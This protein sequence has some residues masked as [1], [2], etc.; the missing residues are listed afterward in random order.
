MIE[1]TAVVEGPSRIH[2]DAYVGHF[3]LLG[4]PRP[5]VMNGSGMSSARRWESSLG[6]T[7]EAGAVVEAY[8]QVADASTIA[9]GAS[10]GP[11][12]YVGHDTYIG[13]GAELYYS[14]QVFNR[15]TVGERA[16]IGGFVC[17]DV[18]IGER[19]MVFGS[20]IHRLVDAPPAATLPRPSVTEPFPRVEADAV[21]GMG[22]IVIGGVVVGRGAYVAAG[23]ILNSDAEPDTLYLGAPAR[24]HG[25]APRPFGTNEQN[26][27]QPLS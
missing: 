2:P 15:V 26:A 16:V 1:P 23:A 20:L 21:I 25:P 27:G 10:V 11:R 24:P 14:C 9:R 7:V 17:N 13:E 19:A 6:V 18:C 12:C 8:A 3:A 5:L 22:A 4:Q